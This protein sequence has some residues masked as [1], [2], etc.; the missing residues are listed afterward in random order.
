[1]GVVRLALSFQHP[2][3]T[4]LSVSLIFLSGFTIVSLFLIFGLASWV[5]PRI[6]IK[7]SEGEVMHLTDTFLDSMVDK[8]FLEPLP[9]EVLELQS[10]IRHDVIDTVIYFNM[11][12]W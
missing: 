5:P 3:L 2:D 9:S 10:F 11:L 8:H 12:F 1:M 4:M 6:L 7:R